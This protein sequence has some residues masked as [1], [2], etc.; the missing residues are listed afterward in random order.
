MT[1]ARLPLRNPRAPA[2][3]PDR[4]VSC[5]GRG[6][7]LKCALPCLVI[8]LEDSMK[9]SQ[10][11]DRDLNPMSRAELARYRYEVFVGHLGWQLP[12]KGDE[13]QDQFDVASAVHI[14]A[15]DD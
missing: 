9:L 4:F 14:V 1:A 11:T 6:A 7:R 15:R 2:R 5:P 8:P 13:D 3:R 12:I 10:I